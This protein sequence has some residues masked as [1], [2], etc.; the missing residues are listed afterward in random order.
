M[1]IFS[2][3][4]LLKV[5]N[6][7]NEEFKITKKPEYKYANLMV[8]F[9]L[10]LFSNPIR[11]ILTCA[12]VIYPSKYKAMYFINSFIHWYESF[13]VAIRTFIRIYMDLTQHNNNG[14]DDCDDGGDD[15]GCMR[16]LGR[17]Q[18]RR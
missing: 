3:Y 18:R 14:D 11:K 6:R 5:I 8:F 1:A 10:K 9:C 13:S 2:A 16:A 12:Y 15:D 17:K 7:D 4:S